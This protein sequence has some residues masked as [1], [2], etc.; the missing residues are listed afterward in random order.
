MRNTRSLRYRWRATP[1]AALAAADRSIALAGSSSPACYYQMRG[2]I[3]HRLGDL[4][5]ARRDLDQAVQKEPG[6]FLMWSTRAHIELEQGQ[7]AVARDDARRAQ[8]LY[9]K[10]PLDTITEALADVFLDDVPAAANLLRGV[11]ARAPSELGAPDFAFEEAM[12]E[13][14]AHRTDSAAHACLA[15]GLLAAARGDGARA[16]ADFD[17]A[18]KL[19]AM[20]ASQATQARGAFDL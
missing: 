18:V 13:R 4:A 2:M 9:R 1:Q 16:K 14:I 11:A 8:A 15:R 19:D 12:L 5:G 7:Y 10:H 20:L 17:R 3:R 6:T